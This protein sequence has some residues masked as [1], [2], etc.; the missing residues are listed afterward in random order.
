MLP[1]WHTWDYR[2]SGLFVLVA[3]GIAPLVAAVAVMFG[4]PIA[5]Q[6]TAIVGLFAI[7]WAV[8]QALVLHVEAPDVQVTLG[9]VGV[10]LLL[11]AYRVRAS[12]RS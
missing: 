6:A 10:V 8:W 4:G 7:F 1:D 3:L 9:V 2:Y 11:G 12:S 5:Y